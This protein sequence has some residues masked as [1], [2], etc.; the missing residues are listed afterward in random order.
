[1]D[2]TSP[3]QMVGMNNNIINNS[4]I[5][6]QDFIFQDFMDETNFDQFIS[7]IREDNIINQSAVM[8]ASVRDFGSM[9]GTHFGPIPSLIPQP[10]VCNDL[11]HD[12]AGA[13][14]DL[15]NI[16]NVGGGGGGIGDILSTPDTA[17][18]QVMLLQYDDQDD[19]DEE[20]YSSAT[21]M[22][23]TTGGNRGSKSDRSRTL[24]SERKRRGRMKEKLYSLRALV[25]NITKMDKASIVGDAVLYVQD[26]QQQSKKL[27]AEIA[28]LQSSSSSSLATN[29]ERNDQRS[30]T[31]TSTIIR[32]SPSSILL[33][34]SPFNYSIIEMD[35][36][37]VEERG[38]YVRVGC[39]R[40]KGVA[41]SLYKALESLTATFNILNSNLATAT[42]D[43]MRFIFTF[44]LNQV[45]SGSDDQEEA[46][47][48]N[49]Q[50]LKLWI[51]GAFMNQGFH[52]KFQP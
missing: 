44:T 18:D 48:M 23:R 29:G 30:S 46:A 5:L 43:Q 27:K 1:M 39:N 35:M 26:L 19:P 38:L 47:E 37:K 17:Q 32:H 52:F 2:N 4:N 11:Y 15:F 40:G 20:D 25:P 24:V 21:T 51:A 28:N 9:V 34:Q 49:L 10:P 41:V 3:F 42:T 8:D 22:T 6:S 33:N 7:L 50:T 16:L 36:F 14:V 13:D 12:G 31:D 45:R